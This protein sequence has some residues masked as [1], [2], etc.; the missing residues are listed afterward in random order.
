MKKRGLAHLE[1]VM[2]FVIFIGVIGFGF[3]FLG[4]SNKVNLVEKNLDY[5]EREI[6]NDLSTE[7]SEQSLKIITRTGNS[8]A[9][10]LNR[11][12]GENF[13]I[14]N[15]SGDVVNS[16]FQG[17]IFYFDALSGDIYKIIKSKEI[18]ERNDLSGSLPDHDEN[19][20]KLGPEIE[21]ELFSEKKALELNM[22]Y[23]ENYNGLLER[24]GVGNRAN[25]G[26]QVVFADGLAV[27][28]KK[29][30]PENYEIFSRNERVEFLRRDG[31]LEF[32]E[33]IVLVW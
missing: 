4:N 27:I 31:K 14:E 16:K 2:A 1:I 24:Y 21:S 26:F 13:A 20:Y 28:A 10:E 30:V 17:G 11:E 29:S 22:S 18:S 25:F 15:S 5:I 19:N 23:Y 33:V 7:A 12:N 6:K 3:Y 32:A 8:F 9:V